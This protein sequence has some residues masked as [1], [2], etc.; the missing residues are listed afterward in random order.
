ME[1]INELNQGVQEQEVIG[2]EEMFEETKESYSEPVVQEFV[3][4]EEDENDSNSTKGLIVLAGG[5]VV[6]GAALIAGRKKLSE[7]NTNRQIKRLTKLG[8]KIE[9]DEEE[10][11]QEESD[12]KTEQDDSKEEPNKE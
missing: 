8:Y 3:Y 11:K 2:G 7:W 12:D 1:N 4:E 9:K 10:I 6:V 5:V